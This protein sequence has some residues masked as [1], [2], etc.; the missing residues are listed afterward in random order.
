MPTATARHPKNKFKT[1]VKR[2]Q[3]D[4]LKKTDI[5]R[6]TGLSYD[7]INKYLRQATD[8]QATL[9]TFKD[10]L[11]ALLHSD[12][13]LGMELKHRV[14]VSIGEEDLASMPMGERTR[15]IGALQIGNGI[16]YDK[17]RLQ[18]GKSTVNSSHRIQLDSVHDTLYVAA[19]PT[20]LVP[21]V[22]S[23]SGNPCGIMGHEGIDSTQ[24]IEFIDISW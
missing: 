17:I 7:T 6:L 22:E 23:S 10:N 8:D 24:P 3:A 21:V 16:A 11:S 14:L 4:G 13:L 1:S 20:P 5:V 18:D 9:H 12:L 2:M 19:K 15:L